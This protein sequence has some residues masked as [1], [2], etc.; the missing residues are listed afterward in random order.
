MFSLR[1]LIEYAMIVYSNQWKGV[2]MSNEE[3]ILSALESLTGK[4]DAI[5]REQQEMKREMAES[6]QELSGVKLEMAGIKQ[7]QL[8]MKREMAEFRQELSELKHEVAGIKKTLDAVFDHVVG[9][10]EPQ[11][12]TNNTIKELVSITKENTYDILK[13]KIAL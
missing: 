5:A 1:S 4:V 10:T 13:L 3:R 8:E 6:R 12:I 11:T 7:E 2:S 9:L